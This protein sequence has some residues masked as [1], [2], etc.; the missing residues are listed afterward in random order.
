VRNRSLLAATVGAL[1]AL[2]IVGPRL[3]AGD[4]LP[5][6]KAVA[7]GRHVQVIAPGTNME[8]LHS[9]LK[10]SAPTDLVLQVTLECTIL[11]QLIT[12]GTHEES[13]MSKGDILVWAEFDDVI[14]PIQDTSA[15]ADHTAGTG[16]DAD[17]VTF[18]NRTYQRSVT[19]SENPSDGTDTIS[20]YIETKSAHSFNWMLLNAGSGTHTIRV[21]ANLTVE[22]TPDSLAKAYVGNRTLIVEPA[23][24]ANDAVIS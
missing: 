13:A 8:L 9:T 3:A 18:C 15:P 4:G 23:R 24:L 19:D 20:D 21:L 22:S 12:G 7:S 16:T 17:K 10:T 5:A 14:V 1:F 6:D 11:T 2:S